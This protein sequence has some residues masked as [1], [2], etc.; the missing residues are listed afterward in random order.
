MSDPLL[1]QPYQPLPDAMTHYPQYFPQVYALGPGAEHLVEVRSKILQK[2]RTF[3]KNLSL[4]FL[5]EMCTVLRILTEELPSHLPLYLA[6]NL[7]P[8]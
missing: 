3:L 1:R 4:I 2:V 5:S 7:L 6:G 8:F